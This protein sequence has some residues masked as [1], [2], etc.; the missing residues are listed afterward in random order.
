MHSYP[1]AYVNPYLLSPAPL[2]VKQVPSAFPDLPK[3]L[4]DE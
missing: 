2:F 4:V 1:D 3:R